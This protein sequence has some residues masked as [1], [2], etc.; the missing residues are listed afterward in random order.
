MPPAEIEWRRARPR[1]SRRCRRATGAPVLAT[2][3]RGGTNGCARALT[4]AASVEFFNLVLGLKLTRQD[5]G[6]LVAFM[7]RL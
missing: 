4:L 5:K 3:A 1:R 6:K 7:R 2:P